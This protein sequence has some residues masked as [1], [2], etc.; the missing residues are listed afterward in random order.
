MREH[1]GLFFELVVPPGYAVG[2]KIKV[3][4]IMYNSLINDFFLLY[5]NTV[6]VHFE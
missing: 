2:G 1:H 6:E 4:N 3:Q 5:C